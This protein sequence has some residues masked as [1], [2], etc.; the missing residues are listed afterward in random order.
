[1]SA[2]SKRQIVKHLVE[3][4]EVSERHACQVVGLARS[5][6][7]YQ[8]RGRAEEAQLVE[9]IRDYAYRYPQHGYRHISALM[10]R[11]GQAVNHKRIERLWRREGLQLPR[12]KQRKRRF[13]EGGDVKRRAEYRHHV[14]SY[15]FTEDRTTRGQKIR[16]LAIMDE[17]T[18]EN[19]M[20]FAARSIP[21][22]RVWDI[23]QWLFGIHGVPEHLRSDNGPE[24]IANAIK[25][26]LAQHDCQTIFIQPGHPWENPFIE[27]FIGTLRHECL[28]RYLFDH[29]PE[30]QHIMDHWR[31]EYNQYRP[32]SSLGY[33]T[34]AE[35]AQLSQQ[36][37]S[38]TP[39]GT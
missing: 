23:L 32:H 12:R 39:I 15:D 37:I 9:V 3:A 13:G 27:R 5:T 4:H 8:A 36:A 28:D 35:F 30:A 19:L 24:F 34:P 38:L 25:E 2:S 16:T 29:I 21:S 17:Y 18:R 11:A 26:N 1:M 14:W 31:I 20:L 10:Q 22:A 6:A 7:R 33:R